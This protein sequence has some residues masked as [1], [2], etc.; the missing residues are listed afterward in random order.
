MPSISQRTTNGSYNIYY[1]KY[2]YSSE[3]VHP[4]PVQSEQFLMMI[5]FG[6]NS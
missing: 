2:T 6:K 4:I 3:T 1:V 5:S